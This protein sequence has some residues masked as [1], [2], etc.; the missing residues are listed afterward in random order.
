MRLTAPL[1]GAGIVY[2]LSVVFDADRADQ[3][4]ERVLPNYAARIVGIHAVYLAA[5]R[6]GA[7]YAGLSNG[8]K[9]GLMH[10]RIEAASRSRRL[11][12]PPI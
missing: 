6:A 2:G 3:R 1:S 7:R 4:L 8:W 5:R 9:T 10:R 12:D 11:S